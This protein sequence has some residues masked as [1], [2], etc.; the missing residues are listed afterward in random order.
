MLEVD[1]LNERA[2]AL[3]LSNPSIAKQLAEQA[4][5][6]SLQIDYAYGHGCAL[7]S[8]AAASVEQS[9]SNA[10]AL[11]VHAIEIF[12]SLGMMTE[13]SS[14]LMPIFCYYVQNNRFDR[15]RRTLEEALTISESI[16]DRHS[17][18]LIYY[19]FGWLACKEGESERAREYFEKS[20]ELGSHGVND[21]SYWR[22]RTR[23]I[24]L[25]VENGDESEWKQEIEIL[26]AGVSETGN[27]LALSD[28]LCLHIDACARTGRRAEVITALRR[29]RQRKDLL[30]NESCRAKMMCAHAN[31]LLFLGDEKKYISRLRRT[32][33]AL[34]KANLK[35]R[36][37]KLLF[38]LAIAEQKAGL[39]EQS[40]CHFLQH[41]ELQRH[42]QSSDAEYRLSE[43]IHEAVARHLCGKVDSAVSKSD[44]LIEINQRLQMS[45]EQQTLLQHELMRI[46]STDELT[47]AVNRRQ[48][49]NDG[50]LEMERYRHTG[51]PFSV[52]VIDVDHFKS[53]NDNFGHATGDEVLRRLTKCCQALLR[54]FDVFGRIGGEEFCIVHHDTDLQGAQMAVKRVMDAVGKMFTADILPDREF[55]VSIGVAEV[56]ES[57]ASFYDVLHHA[58]M[59]L[60]EAKRAGRNTYRLAQSRTLE[61]A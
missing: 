33:T 32:A 8:L 57:D 35:V 24:G 23:L 7:R 41:I 4:R 50:I 34:A 5:E 44:Q 14:A 6:K 27:I 55:S 3:R 45:L 20:I 56:H 54:R 38:H 2:Y 28:A 17:L 39:Y 53:I 42:I 30:H 15:A 12:T 36:L 49:V 61:A 48:I 52:T 9:L 11:A 59:A 40:A 18:S 37:G 29:A 10:F 47:G 58:D 19:N 25:L 1:G 31:A 16:K 22:S 13:T 43:V 26:F 60:F 46:A 51:S 21:W